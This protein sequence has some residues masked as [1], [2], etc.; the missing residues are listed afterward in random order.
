VRTSRFY[1]G[2]K[3]ETYLLQELTK[4]LTLRY[5]HR[6]SVFENQTLR[7]IFGPKKEL[8]ENRKA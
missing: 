2:V 5:I 1:K 7:R 3:E 8:I 6:L 4:S